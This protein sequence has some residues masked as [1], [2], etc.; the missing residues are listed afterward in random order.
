MIAIKNDIL[1]GKF[2]KSFKLLYGDVEAAKIRYCNAVDNFEK[3]Y[4]VRDNVRLFSA[5]VALRLVVTIPT[6][7]TVVF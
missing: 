1:N 5:P 3:I 2:D 6:I 7:S 4:G